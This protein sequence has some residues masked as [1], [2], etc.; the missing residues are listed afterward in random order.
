M[1]YISLILASFTM[2]PNSVFYQGLNY[3]DQ[4]NNMSSGCSRPDALYNND[5]YYDPGGNGCLDGIKIQM[6]EYYEMYKKFSKIDANLNLKSDEPYYG[7]LA[8]LPNKA[9][10]HEVYL[11][12]TA[13]LL[14]DFCVDTLPIENC[15]IYDRDYQIRDEDG[16]FDP[17]PGEIDWFWRKTKAQKKIDPQ[18]KSW[19]VHQYDYALYLKAKSLG[20]GKSESIG[21]TI[22]EAKYLERFRSKYWGGYYG[23]YYEPLLSF[24]PETH[25]EY[26]CPG[27]ISLRY[28]GI[29]TAD[30]TF[31]LIS[32]GAFVLGKHLASKLLKFSARKLKNLIKEISPKV[33][34]QALK[35]MSKK[36]LAKFYMKLA[37]QKRKNTLVIFRNQLFERS[38]NIA[39]ISK[40][41]K[42][43]G[44]K[45]LKKEKKAL[46]RAHLVGKS[47]GAKVGE[48]TKEEIAEKTALLKKAGFGKQIKLKDGKKVAEWN[49]LMKKG[50]AGSGDE[51]ELALRGSRYLDDKIDDIAKAQ[52]NGIKKNIDFPDDVSNIASSNNFQKSIGEKYFEL[53]RY[54]TDLVASNF[55]DTFKQKS[56]KK[57]VRKT[58][59]NIDGALRSSD[60]IQVKALN[61]CQANPTCK[62]MKQSVLNLAEN[63]THHYKLVLKRY[64]KKVA[65]RFETKEEFLDYLEGVY[66]DR[67]ISD[68]EYNELKQVISNG[69]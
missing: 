44:R 22:D 36:E 53:E 63:S 27:E 56:L 51:V 15:K 42:I 32:G 69:L 58:L 13:T 52:W 67:F 29:R 55:D 33:S 46:I 7:R 62:D 2:F 50:V 40:A 41:E 39:R 25:A 54:Y 11:P 26:G 17:Q 60:F 64:K 66:D 34:E 12:E 35:K 45:L 21:L 23:D 1:I 10:Y 8:R 18:N 6:D 47:R 37:A 20:F 24:D 30:P 4:K 48:F 5:K 65:S 57:A 59:D 28:A 9:L 43:L 68:F 16:N 38:E 14:L 61:K 3:I 19:G 49:L 31:D